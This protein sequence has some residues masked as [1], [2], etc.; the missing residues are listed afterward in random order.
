ERRHRVLATA[1][2]LGAEL[3][4]LGFT[5]TARS[6]TPAIPV[7]VGDTR[8]C[9]RL[10]TELFNEGV[11]TNALTP[12]SVPE[13]QALV[14]VGVTAAHTRLQVERIVEAFANAGHR[15]KLIEPGRRPAETT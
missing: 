14:R 10:W 5:T 15:L 8:L 4:A 9:R 7:L 13:G 3:N 2:K 6:R 11:F 12:P 1:E